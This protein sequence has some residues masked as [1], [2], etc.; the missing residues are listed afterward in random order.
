MAGTAKRLK[1]RQRIDILRGVLIQGYD[2]IGFQ[3]ARTATIPAP[4][5]VTLKHLAPDGGPSAGVQMDMVMA[6]SI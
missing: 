2:V 6:H 1:A 5:A 3:T 4:V